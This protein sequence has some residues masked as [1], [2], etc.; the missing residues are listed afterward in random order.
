MNK[1]ITPTVHTVNCMKNFGSWLTEKM[2][3]TKTSDE[4]LAA[5][6]DLDRKTILRYRHC[7]SVPK[8]DVVAAIFAYFGESTI[9]ISLLDHNEEV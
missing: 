3:E 5:H 8:L 7:E 4:E 1:S 6:V 9:H 2:K